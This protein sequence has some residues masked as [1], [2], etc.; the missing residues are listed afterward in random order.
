MKN[1]N[2]NWLIYKT[3][4]MDIKD[5]I[6]R[7]DDLGKERAHLGSMVQE[8]LNSVKELERDYRGWWNENV[9]GDVKGCVVEGRIGDVVVSAPPK[10]YKYSF[11][12]E[13]PY[14]IE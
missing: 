13:S 3:F 9:K 14:I 4:E 6:K 11:Q 5:L 7:Q 12:I 2:W 1:W 8:H 10:E